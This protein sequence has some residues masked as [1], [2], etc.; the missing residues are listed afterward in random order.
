MNSISFATLFAETS[1]DVLHATNNLVVA[2]LVAYGAKH[3]RGKQQLRKN[4]R[5][6]EG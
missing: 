2:A 4:K 3:T 6:E 5:A 1:A